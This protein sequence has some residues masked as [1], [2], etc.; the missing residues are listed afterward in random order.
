M[1]FYSSGGGPAKGPVPAGALLKLVVRGVVDVDGTMAWREGME[2]WVRLETALGEAVVLA[3]SRF[4]HASGGERVGPVNAGELCRL[5]QAGDV[6]GLTPIWHDRSTRWEALSEVSGLRELLV[7]AEANEEH[8]DA[9]EQQFEPQPTLPTQPKKRGFVAD[10]GRAFAFE[11]GE[12]KQVDAVDEE[13][14]EEEERV[15]EAPAAAP[16][17]KERKKKKKKKTFDKK[18]AK[19]WIYVQGLPSD[20]TTEELAAHFSK[21]GIIATDPETAM[22]KIKI[23]RD[24]GLVKGDA[25]ICYANAGSV[26]LAVDVL[27]GGSLRFGWQLKVSQADF[28]EKRLG[29]Y[30]Q[31]KR[32]RVNAIRAKNAKRATKQLAQWDADEDAVGAVDAL[33]ILVV[34]GAFE[35]RKD[36][37]D[38]LERQVLDALSAD[39]VEPPEKVVVFPN[40]PDGVV[41]VKTKTPNDAH[42]VIATLHNRPSFTSPDRTMR[43]F[44]W[45]GV[46]NYRAPP[47]QALDDDQPDDD[48]RLDDFGDWLEQKADDLPA[49]LRLQV[50]S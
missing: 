25:S 21:C 6:D 36:S 7:Q 30:D 15:A 49:E 19:C 24:N 22:P 45:D 14:E 38:D 12:W 48:Q 4:Y 1:W 41:V 43:C 13:E 37:V 8:Y 9:A 17:K 18:A 35:P 11:E 16:Q 40:H 10:D 33:R 26:D 50:E 31:S 20:A 47:A 23:Y 34:E 39:L 42:V 5:L 28:S 32:R 29:D 44:F 46:T 27:D 3:R 2:A